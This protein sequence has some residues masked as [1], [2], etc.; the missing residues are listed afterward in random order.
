MDRLKLEQSTLR[1]ADRHRRGLPGRL[2]PARHPGGLLLGRG[3]PLRRPAAVP[4]GDAGAARPARGPARGAA[5]RSATCPR[6]PGRGSAASTSSPR[7]TRTSRTTCAPSRRRRDTADL[8]EASGEAIAREFESYLK[9]RGE[10]LSSRRPLNPTE[11]LDDDAPSAARPP[12][13]ATTSAGTPASSSDGTSRVAT[14]VASQVEPQPSAAPSGASSHRQ[15]G[16]APAATRPRRAARREVRQ[17]VGRRE[18]LG[19]HRGGGRPGTQ[20]ERPAPRL[21]R[22]DGVPELG[23]EPL[24]VAAV[25]VAQQ[26]QPD[27][28]RVDVAVAQRARRRPGCPATSTSSRRRSRPSRRARRPG[29]SAPRVRHLGLARAH[30]VVREDQVAAAGLDVERGAEVLLRDRGALDVPAGPP[31]PERAVPARLA[32][33][34]GRARPRSRAGPSCRAVGVAAALGEDLQHLLAAAAGHLAERR[35]GGHR[36]V[37]VV[38]DVVDRPGCLAAARSA[39]RRAGS[40]RR[41][42]RSGRAAGPAAPPCPGGTARSHA[43]RARPSRRA[44]RS[45][46][47][48]SG[49]STSVTFCT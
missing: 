24:P 1:G 10:R 26:H 28:H 37:E 20:R 25:V 7:R 46:R 17:V 42:R 15:A 18:H 40:T 33:S 13:S 38:L 36:E 31:G 19:D 3:P 43:R 2:R 21:E 9:R 30:L 49:S 4:E 34:L 16:V 12:R 32:G 11:R 6:T 45:A 22:V 8:P 14:V 27:R 29:R 35:V 5:S 47:S 41:R 39:R 48:S 23:V 44:P